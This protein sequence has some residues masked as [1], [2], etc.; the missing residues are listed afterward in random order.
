MKREYMTAMQ[1]KMEEMAKSDDRQKQLLKMW[2]DAHGCGHD[3]YT[4]VSNKKTGESIL[5][6]PDHYC[7]P[8]Q[9]FSIGRNETSITITL[10]DNVED[11][12]QLDLKT[13]M[14][15]SPKL[16]MRHLAKKDKK[17]PE[18]IKNQYES[19]EGMISRMNR[20]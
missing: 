4:S 6:D 11:S 7:N 8:K 10:D 14:A 19:L 15:S 13:E 17:K 12:L 1:D 20:S 18:D 3:V 5:H 9:P 16:L 2:K